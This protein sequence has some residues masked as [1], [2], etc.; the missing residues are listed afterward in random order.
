MESVRMEWCH[1]GLFREFVSTACC[2]YGQSN[3][4]ITTSEQRSEQKQKMKRYFGHENWRTCADFTALVPVPPTI[5]QP[6][7]KPDQNLPRSCSKRTPPITTTCAKPPHDRPSTPQAKCV[8][9]GRNEMSGRELWYGSFCTNQFCHMPTFIIMTNMLLLL[10][11]KI[12]SVI[13]PGWGSAW[14]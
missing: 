10:F 3:R 2:T 12:S 13:K 5:P 11:Q 14:N 9:L 1:V 8:N 6:S 7:P 4:T